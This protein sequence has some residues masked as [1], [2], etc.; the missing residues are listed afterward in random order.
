MVRNIPA[1][2]GSVV[3][4]GRD[5]GAPTPSRET[6]LI[7][8]ANLVDSQLYQQYRVCPLCR[9]NYCIRARER[10][11]SLVD[12]GSFRE[13][14]RSIVSLDP[15]SF[16]SR[17]PYKQRIFRDQRR[18][19]LTEAAVTGTCT[20][21]GSPAMLIV[22]D[23]G[24]MGGTIGCVVG[25]K[26]ALALERAVKRNLP[27]VAVITSG[28]AR[29]QEGVLSLMQMAKTTIT[30]NKINEKGL[31]IVSILANPATGQAY[32]S[33]TSLGDIVLAE[34][35][36]IIGYSPIRAIKETS[37]S[38]S[39]REAH[40]AEA[41][42]KNGMIDAVV[43]RT[44]MRN[45]VGTLLDLLGPQYLLTPADKS[46]TREAEAER[47]EAWSSVQL[48]R[49]ESRPTAIDYI[50]SMFTNFVELHGDRCYGDDKSI[51]C[52]FGHLGGQTVTIIGQERGRGSGGDHND[53]RTSPEGFR[54]AQR[55]L[56]LASKF[57]LPLVTLIDTPG[58][59]LSTDAEMRG[60]GNAIASTMSMIARLEVPSI[61]VVIGEGGSGGALALGV[62][63]RVLMMENAIYSPVSPEEAAEVMYQDEARAEEAAVSLKL[64]AR[65]CRERGIVD[66]VVSEPPGGAHTNPDEASRG[67]RRAL[68]Q[69]L[70]TLQ[71]G[72]KRRMLQRRY[73]KFRKMGEYSSHFRAAVTREVATL[74]GRMKHIV[75]RR[76]RKA[77]ENGDLDDLM[78]TLP[79]QTTTG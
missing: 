72:S 12:P 62:T 59:N 23:F 17:M 38:P 68:L 33:F 67:L 47:P 56:R 69:E 45:I 10:I 76:S 27:T 78:A 37:G 8:G 19:G 77:I 55:A 21:G 79:E 3:R 30:A 16:S 31:P 60:L 13:T 22:L 14:N 57:S 66:L 34:P 1:L 49:H 28:G 48:A 44:E 11:D 52:G 61:S 65:D 74:Q 24:F 50:K 40:T 29:I 5:D 20:I 4:R 54:K 32:A 70:A 64:T 7:D 46:R 71:S 35:D 58:P 15:L 39:P 36:A 51:V 42:L 53:G 6:C 41:H 9:F 63:D 26:V 75:R 43:D 18:T 25:E 73:K 2:L